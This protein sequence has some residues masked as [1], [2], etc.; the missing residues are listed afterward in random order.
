MPNLFVQDLRRIARGLSDDPKEWPYIPCPT[1]KR[2]GLTVVPGSLVLEEANQS[3]SWR[4]LEYWDVDFIYGAF[5]CVLRCYKETC[6]LVRVV[7]RTSIYME[8]TEEGYKEL[9]TPLFFM[10][11]LPLMQD[12]GDCPKQVRERIEAASTILWADPSSAANRLRSAVEALMDHEGI[13]RRGFSKG[14]S[15]DISLHN[16]IERFKVAKPEFSEAANLVLAVKWTGNFGSH[17][18]EIRVPDVLDA[19]DILDRTIQYIYDTSAAG[20]KKKAEEIIARKGM[21]A[22]QITQFPVPP[23]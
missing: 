11:E 13:P 22:S 10:P 18:G 5:H 2:A 6:D 21:P 15:Y 9:L 12:F 8:N 16:R 4:A 17:G 23:F 1:C 3:Q 7:G 14:K 20:I 19:I